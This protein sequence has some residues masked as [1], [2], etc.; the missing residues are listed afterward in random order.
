M[1]ILIISD[2]HRDL[3]NFY[4]V[5][6]RE[7]PVDLCLHLG[8]VESDAIPIQK[9][10]QCPLHM[11]KGNNDFLGQLP[12]EIELKLGPHKLFM[13]HGHRYMVS[14]GTERL[15]DE[16]RSIGADLV[17]Y[18]HTHK[19]LIRTEKDITILC[20]GSISYPRQ[21]GRQFTYIIMDM[22]EKGSLQFSLKSL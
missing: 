3:K 16:A 13:T 10:L 15:V 22:D 18:G 14:I 19:P 8:D 20:P 5:L 1:K 17:M 7:A 21:S 6:K 4:E 12:E 2:T 11:V 9:K